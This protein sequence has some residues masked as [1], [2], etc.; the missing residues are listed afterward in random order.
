MS[1]G[2]AFRGITVFRKTTQVNGKVGNS[3]PLPQSSPKFAGEIKS[4]TPTPMQNFIMIRLPPWPPT[5]AKMR[6]KWLGRLFSVPIPCTDFHDHRSIRQMTRFRAM[7]CL[8]GS[9]KQNLTFWTYSP[10]KKTQIFRQ[11]STGLVRWH[12]SANELF[13]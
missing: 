9:R 11:F 3:T 4:G 10:P 2:C 8:L 13:F 5:Y 6:I 1:Q 7:M 12:V